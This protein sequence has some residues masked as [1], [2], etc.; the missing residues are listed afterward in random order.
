MPFQHTIYIIAK[1]WSS[2]LSTFLNRLDELT[3]VI[4]LPVAIKEFYRSK[5][6][7]LRLY[8]YLSLP[9]FALIIT[10]FIAGAV[11]VNPFFITVHGMFDY[12]KYILVI[13]IYAAFFRDVSELNKVLR[14]LLIVAVLLGAAAFIQEVWA[15]SNRYILQKNIVNIDYLDLGYFVKGDPKLM[16]EAGDERLTWKLGLYRVPSLLFN[17]VGSGLYAL[18]IFTLYMC[19][20][21][22]DNLFVVF[23]LLSGIVGSISRIVYS[24]FLFVSGWLIIKGRKWLLL[25]LIPVG[26]LLY[27]LSFEYDFNIWQ[28]SKSAIVKTEERGSANSDWGLVS[29]RTYTKEKAL[30]IWKDHPVWGAG[31]G[32]YGGPISIDY[33]SSLYEKYNF[34]P[35]AKYMLEKWGSIDQFW[36]QILAEL[37]VAGVI[38][39]TGF[40]IVLS[41]TLIML[42]KKTFLYEE[43]GVL[44]GLLVYLVVILLYTL[45]YTLNISPII[46]TYFAL[47]GISLSCASRINREA[48]K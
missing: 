33:K 30:N 19:I 14:G 29:Y 16:H 3:I 17:G 32:T 31:P 18:L 13:Y 46:F 40:F 22:K 37:G 12:I 5:D 41:L 9:I 45:G 27:G 2:K 10:G 26:L 34:D 25:L 15:V 48:S 20:A 39:F 36:P 47:V 21:K 11:N 23:C 38:C 42:I 7:P 4:L 24:G 8:C 1:L 44:T 28:F 6:V 43:R 35:K